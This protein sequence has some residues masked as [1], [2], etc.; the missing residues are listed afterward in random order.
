MVPMVWVLVPALGAQTAVG[1]SSPMSAQAFFE[2]FL[3]ALN[4]RDWEK[5]RGTF[6]DD[7]TV[8]FDHPGP[9]IRQ[10]GRTA[11][12][13]LF[14]FIFPPPGATPRALPPPVQPFNLKVQDLGEAAVISF[15]FKDENLVVRRTLVA[16]RTPAGWR[17]VHIHG[18]S[19]Q[20]PTP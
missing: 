2:S 10:D 9:P 11:V 20:A 4:Q 8:M 12:E 18:S 15:H 16:R 6:A 13:A 1:D 5:F 7:I 14:R 3:S 17:V 19:A